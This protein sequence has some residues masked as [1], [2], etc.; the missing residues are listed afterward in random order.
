MYWSAENPEHFAADKFPTF[1]HIND[2]EYFEI[3][4]IPINEYSGLLRV[5]DIQICLVLTAIFIY[6]VYIDSISFWS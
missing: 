1:L 4:G 2:E 6:C 3:Y 5:N